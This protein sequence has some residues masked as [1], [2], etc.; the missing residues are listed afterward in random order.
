MRSLR[1]ACSVQL[2]Q[3]LSSEEINTSMK[4]YFFKKGKNPGDP[5]GGP[6]VKTELQ[7]QVAWVQPFTG[8]L[9]PIS[10]N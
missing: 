6:V 1:T 7:M 10:H 3:G 4:Q 5:P 9:D 8:E 2:E